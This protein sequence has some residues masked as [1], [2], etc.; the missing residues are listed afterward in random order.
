MLLAGQLITRF[1]IIG[2]IYDNDLDQLSVFASMT[3]SLLHS[4][5][6]HT[7]LF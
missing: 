4:Q 6:A 7:S 1:D 3:T 5:S 2:L